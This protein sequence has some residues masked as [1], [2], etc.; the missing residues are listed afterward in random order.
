MNFQNQRH[1][2]IDYDIVQNDEPTV[3]F[4]T[5]AT[6]VRSEATMARRTKKVAKMTVKLER[7]PK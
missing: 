3:R 1:K 7:V 5:A 2:S 4:A 6:I